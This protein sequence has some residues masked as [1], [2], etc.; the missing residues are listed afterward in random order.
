MFTVLGVHSNWL[1]ALPILLAIGGAI[2]FAARATPATSIAH[3]RDTRIALAA[4][5][6]WVVVSSVAPVI[7]SDPIT[8]LEGGWQ[9]FWLIG[10][11]AV[12]ALIACRSVAVQPRGRALLGGRAPRARRPDVVDLQ[13]APGAAA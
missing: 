10:I 3:P 11:G 5:G 2:A 9:A 12:A 13:H 8:P 1:A 6:A 4:I 7:S